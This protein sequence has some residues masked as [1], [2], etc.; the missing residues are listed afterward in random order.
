[1]NRIAWTIAGTV[2]L[3]TASAAPLWAQRGLAVGSELFQEARVAPGTS[4]RGQIV[5]RNGA[6]HEQ[7]L[8][9]TQHDFRSDYGHLEY[10]LEPGTVPRS[11]AAWVR[12]PRTVVT[13]PADSTVAIPF[14]V[15]IPDTAAP[16]TYWS[17]V[18][19]ARE[20][21]EVGRT[22][23]QVETGTA[24]AT[25]RQGVGFV[26]LV[27]THIGTVRPALKLAAVALDEREGSPVVDVRF[28]NAGEAMAR[29][30]VWVEVFREDGQ[31]LGRFDARL[32]FLFPGQRVT[33]PVSM[34]GVG[35][36]RYLAVLYVD[37]GT[38]V[39]GSRLR[40][41]VEPR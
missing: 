27:V 2:L 22:E 24:T 3:L 25:I 31:P 34:T 38:E 21:V 5:V 28:E 37:D 10:G 6:D 4:H 19:V 15:V 16:G 35:P 17:V 14:D 7:T 13:I 36:G 8:T 20:S 18:R 23:T 1:M 26:T 41:A 11:N 32:N 30:D 33:K 39:T 12:L 9:V 29:A 40:F